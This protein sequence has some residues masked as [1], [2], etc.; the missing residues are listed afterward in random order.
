MRTRPCLSGHLLAVYPWC[1]I[2]ALSPSV[3]IQMWIC[4]FCASSLNNND[5]PGCVCVFL[6]QLQVS[7]RNVRIHNWSR[8]A[9]CKY[10][11]CDKSLVKT[12]ERGREMTRYKD[13]QLLTATLGENYGNRHRRSIDRYWFLIQLIRIQ[14]A[15]C[16]GLLI[17][18][19]WLI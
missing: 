8:D 14:T 16:S 19:K 4:P 5:A 13:A 11:G 7:M 6:D 12:M 1:F 15:S 18:K 2:L 3:T 17:M 9:A 10:T